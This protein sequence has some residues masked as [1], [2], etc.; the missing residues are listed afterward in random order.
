MISHNDLKTHVK[1]YR[2]KWDKSFLLKYEKRSKKNKYILVCCALL[3]VVIVV[4]I[5]QHYN[6]VPSVCHKASEFNIKVINSSVDYNNNG[7]DDY[8][9]IMLGARQDAKNHPT[10]K[11]VYYK[12]G[13][14]PEDE[15]VCTD[16]VW[17]AFKYA[18]YSL[19]DMIDV[20]IAL[21]TADYT[22]VEKPDPNIDFRRVKNLKV[23]FDKYAINLSTDINEIDQWQPG[24]IVIFGNN[25]HIGIVSDKRNSKGQAYIIHNSGQLLREEDALKFWTPTAHYRFDASRVPEEVLKMWE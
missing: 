5:L 9:D 23:F 15:G 20:D 11:S 13:Y 14:P 1:P 3:V 8:T 16:V 19:K 18:G 2:I 10:Y 25:T 24:D 21:R 17:R 7:V 22:N 12:G 4:L 6:V